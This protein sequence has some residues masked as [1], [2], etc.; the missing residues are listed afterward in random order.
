[1]AAQDQSPKK[2]PCQSCR[3]YFITWDQAKPH[4]CRAFGFK[5][6]ILPCYE[7]QVVSNLNCL[8]FEP[9]PGRAPGT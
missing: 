3:F 6:G 4:G 5:S 1:M 8:K 9:K 2:P 7:V